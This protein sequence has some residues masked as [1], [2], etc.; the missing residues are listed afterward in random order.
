MKF[1]AK[2]VPNG[3][4]QEE[5]VT[6]KQHLVDIV[7]CAQEFFREFGRYFTDKEKA[8]V[9]EAC[10]VHDL[11]KANIVFQS[12]INNE[13]DVIKTQEIPHGFLSAMVTSPEEFKNRVPEADNDDYK[14]F[15]T[16]VYH[17]HARED[18]NTDDVILNFCRKYFVQYIREFLNDETIKARVAGINKYLLFRN[19]GSIVGN[20]YSLAYYDQEEYLQKWQEFALIKGLLNKFDYTVS[21]GYTKSEECSDLIKKCLKKSIESIFQHN[22]LRPVQ[23]YMREKSDANLVVVA[24]TGMGKTEAALLWIN[25]EKGFYTLPYVVSSNAIYERIRDRYRYKD[26]AILH[27]D[28]MHYYFEDPV[29]ETDDDSYKK[30]QKAKLLSQP[31]TVCT[32]DQLFKFVYKALGTEIF[33]ATLK[34]SKIIIDEIQAYSPS[35]IATIIYGLK[36]VSDMGGKFAIITATFPPVL[37]SLMQKYGL[38]VDRQYEYRDFSNLSNYKRHWIDINDGDIETN[39]VIKDSYDKKVLVICNTVKKTQKLYSSL[40]DSVDHVH[41]LHARFTKEHK[42][43][44]EKEI[45]KFSNNKDETGIW[46]TTQLVEASL[47]IDFDVLY[48]EMSTADSL[49]Q[50]M[51]RCNRKGRRIPAKPNIHI[52]INANGVGD[53]KAI[54]NY[55]IYCRSVKYLTEYTHGVM[56]ESDKSEYIKKVYCT[57]EIKNSEYYRNIERFLAMFKELTPAEYSKSEVDEKFRDIKSIKIIPDNIYENNRETISECLDIIHNS[58]VDRKAKNDARAKLDSYVIAIQLYAYKKYPDGIDHNVIPGSDIHKSCMRYDFND[59][60]L[61][62]EG[63]ILGEYEKDIFV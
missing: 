4:S 55:E 14:A 31:L 42:R 18:K 57:E 7:G 48:T 61:T 60:D 28:S 1:Y 32:V 17:H 24:P 33:A 59:K 53:N 15:Y 43:M 2:S 63:L 19:T 39:K 27:S 50:R 13:L 56:F 16:A 34:Y 52:Y 36:I 21:A 49:L 54:Y 9:I 38:T 20:S 46:I 23:E 26:V 45:I 25:G 40:I 10:R 51:G 3:V 29:N 22:G 30:Y 6:L 37:G 5:Q 8:M 44:L 47:D 58:D 35:V 41:L 12:K 62:G 11:G